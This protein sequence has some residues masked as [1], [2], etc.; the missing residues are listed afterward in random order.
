MVSKQQRWWWWGGLR[1]WGEH[2][3]TTTYKA[4]S[5]QRL[6]LSTVQRPLPANS[7]DKNGDT[8]GG[9]PV[10]KNPPAD[11]GDAGLIPGLGRSPGEG[12][13]THSKSLAWRRS[14]AG[15][16]PRGL[17]E[18]DTTEQLSTTQHST[19]LLVHTYSLAPS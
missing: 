10:V 18:S 7:L 16:S 2:W 13:G 11:T 8:Y 14:L 3:C 1:A 12:N 5:Q 17:K 4:D 6:L 15:Y 19:H 9:F